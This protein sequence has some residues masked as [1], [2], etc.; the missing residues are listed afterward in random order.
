MVMKWKKITNALTKMTTIFN[1][2]CKNKQVWHESSS[3]LPPKPPVLTLVLKISSAD[4]AKPCFSEG[5]VMKA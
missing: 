4:L 1:H 5:G 3:E 2:Y